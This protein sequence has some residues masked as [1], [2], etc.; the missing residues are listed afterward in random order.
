MNPKIKEFAT[1]ISSPKLCESLRYGQYLVKEDGKFCHIFNINFTLTKRLA[2]NYGQQPFAFHKVDNDC[3]IKQY[4][5]K[6]N[7]SQP[8][9]KTNDYV[10]REESRIEFAIIDFETEPYS[11]LLSLNEQFADMSDEAL[12]RARESVGWTAIRI[13]K[14]VYKGICCQPEALKPLEY[15]RYECEETFYFSWAIFTEDSGLPVKIWIDEGFAYLKY[16]HPLWLYFRNGYNEDAEL[17]PIVI[18]CNP[19]RPY[20]TPLQIT[21]EDFGTLLDFV[22]KFQHELL[23]VA[24]MKYDINDF[25]EN[26]GNVKDVN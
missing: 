11:T 4:Y 26:L 17:D 24:N 1:L 22:C 23:Q 19:Y 9:R 13:R 8:I 12:T 14:D 5:E 6:Q 20:D 18:G 7:P 16:K 25:I 15:Y 21:N 2:A 3:I 10:L